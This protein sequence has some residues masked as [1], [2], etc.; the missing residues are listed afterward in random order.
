MTS[1]PVDG[2]L[3]RWS[4]WGAVAVVAIALAGRDLVGGESWV[5]LDL[6]VYLSAIDEWRAGG[7]LYD[8]GISVG[9]TLLPFTYP[10]FAVIV[11]LPI[12]LLPLAAAQVVWTLTTLVL[13]GVI[14]RLVIVPLVP[15]AS[16]QGWRRDGWLIAGWFA[17]LLSAPVAQTLQLGQVSVAVWTLVIVDLTVMPPRYRGLLTGV[18]AAI[19]LIPMIFLGYFLLTRQWRAAAATVVGFVGATVVGFLVLP[20]ESL[21]YWTVELFR[22][23]RVGEVA[24]AMNK[25]LLGMLSH[26]GWEGPGRVFWLGLVLAILVVGFWRVLQH[27]RRGEEIAAMLVVGLVGGAI[28]PITWLHHLIWLPLA[29]LYLVVIGGRWRWLGVVMLV[30]FSY[31]SPVSTALAELP[32]WQQVIQTS[33]TLAVIGITIFGL[34]RRRA[35]GIGGQP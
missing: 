12:A 18:A 19:K 11:M 25:S 6:W 9:G 13:V 17:M 14:V 4:L 22:T 2:R 29:A 15:A 21:R 27:H 23:D 28:A 8:A 3:L 35:P 26:W 10:P 33:T 24:S 16:L 34:P 32:M 30:A 5:H 31:P 20:Q 7:S 1:A